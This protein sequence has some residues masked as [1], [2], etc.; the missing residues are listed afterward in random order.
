MTTN[1]ISKYELIIKAIVT[2]AGLVILLN[3]VSFGGTAA[4]HWL[5]RYGDSDV[6]SYMTRLTAYIHMYQ[7]FGAVMFGVGLYSLLRFR[8]GN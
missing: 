3:S 4:S 2:L 6:D 7:T 8:K 5:E 1:K